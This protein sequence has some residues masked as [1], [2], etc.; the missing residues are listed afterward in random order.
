MCIDQI[1][2]T[3]EIVSPKVI[4]AVSSDN[5]TGIELTCLPLDSFC[6]EF[7]GLLLKPL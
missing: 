3:Q 4:K 2:P 5:D 1:K 6:K 7:P